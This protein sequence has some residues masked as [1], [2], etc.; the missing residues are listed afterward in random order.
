MV[1]NEVVDDLRPRGRMGL[2]LDFEKAYDWVNRW[3]LDLAMD[4]L[5]GFRSR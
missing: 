1:A 5:K 4:S 3:F 2:L